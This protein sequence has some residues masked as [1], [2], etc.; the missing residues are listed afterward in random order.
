MEISGVEYSIDYLMNEVAKE[1]IF[2]DYSGGG[3]TFCGGEPLLFPDSLHELLLRCKAIGVHRAVDTSLYA[4]SETVAS[5]MKETDI[6]LIDL[7]H[8]DSHKHKQFCGVSNE[9]VLSNL[10]MIAKAGKDFLIRI[11]LI[12]GINADEDNIT[13]SA[14]FLASLPWKRK[15]VNLLPYHEAASD[16]YKKTGAM[17]NPNKIPLSTPTPEQQYYCIEIFQQYGIIATI[18]G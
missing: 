10:R 1:M 2:M 8:M 9:M 3:V 14:E 11:P 4:K 5:I 13:R 12:E 16:K 18:G 15:T 6:F 17:F 7:K